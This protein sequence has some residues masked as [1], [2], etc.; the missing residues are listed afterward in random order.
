MGFRS[1]HVTTL[2]LKLAK[3]ILSSFILAAIL[4]FLFNIMRKEI[5]F[6]YPGFYII[7]LL[8]LAILLQQV[9]MGEDIYAGVG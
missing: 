5:T 4:N 9:V 1:H 2:G 3:T 7:I 6:V 8:Y